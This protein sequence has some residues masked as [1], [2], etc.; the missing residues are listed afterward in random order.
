MKLGRLSLPPPW[1]CNMSINLRVEWKYQWRWVKVWFMA[2]HR[3]TQL[4]KFAGWPLSWWPP[5]ATGPHSFNWT[6]AMAFHYNS[7]NTALVLL[8]LLLLFLLLGYFRLSLRMFADAQLRPFR[9]VMLPLPG[10]VTPLPLVAPV[11]KSG[12]SY[13]SSLPPKRSRHLHILSLSNDKTMGA[14]QPTEAY[15]RLLISLSL[16]LRLF[17]LSMV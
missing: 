5:G 6:L 9:N 11:K 3:R 10:C 8:L 15:R 12:S 14:L 13:S 4:L 1:D 16:S 7:I 2:T 17:N